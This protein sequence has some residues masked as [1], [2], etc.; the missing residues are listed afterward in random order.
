MSHNDF[1]EKLADFFD[2]EQIENLEKFAEESAYDAFGDD[3]GTDD[4]RD[5]VCNLL[6]DYMG[7]E[8]PEAAALIENIA[9]GLFLR[10]TYNDLLNQ[11]K[12]E[13]AE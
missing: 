10:S 7:E 6:Y 8:Y 11:M 9:G 13:N 3:S 5:C 4:G 2:P 12:N 1:V